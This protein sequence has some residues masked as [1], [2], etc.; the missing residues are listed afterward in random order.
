MPKSKEL[1]TPVV[2]LPKMWENLGLHS[3]C[4][5]FPQM[6]D[7]EYDGLVASM[8]DH[9]FLKSDPIVLIDVTPEMPDAV[10][11]IL[12]GRNRHLAAMDSGVTPEFMEYNGD[13]PI[14]FV[15]SRNLDRRH[16]LTGQKAAIASELAKLVSGQNAVNGEMTQAEAAEQVGVGEVSIRR[17]KYV[18]KHDPELAHKVKMGEIPLEKARA[19]IK[20]RLNPDQPIDPGLELPPLPPA[21]EAKVNEAME[22]PA[23]ITLTEAVDSLVEGYCNKHSITDHNTQI[24]IKSAVLAGY[25]LGVRGI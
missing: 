11:E 22:A 4:T 16:L 2:E 13:D 10:Y 23:K 1:L 8:Q 14:S 20:E 6:Q 7:E 17:Y 9:G 21:F 19:E 5:L 24:H 3:L 25:E 12:D 15:T 18:E